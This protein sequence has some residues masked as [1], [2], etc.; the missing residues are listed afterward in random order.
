[1]G[2]R[3]PAPHQD[4]MPGCLALGDGAPEH[5]ALKTSGLMCRSSIQLDE[6]E[7]T[8]ERV[9]QAFM[10]TGSQGKAETPL[11]SGSDLPVVLGGSPGKRGGNC[12]SLWGKDIEDKG[13]RNNY[14][15]ELP[16]RWPFW[17]NLTPTIRAESPRPDN[18]Q[19]APSIS[20]QAATSNHTQRQRP[21]HQRDKNQLNL[22][23]FPIKKYAASPHTNF[24]YKG[25][26]IKSKRGYNPIA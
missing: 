14:Q 7:T 9:T 16:W 21:T 23:V 4:A 22:P 17:K 20:K 26:D 1:M 25:A 8:P 11:E 13:L 15:H 10:C 24:S 2:V 6:M 5:L 18:K 19:G 12:S 3:I